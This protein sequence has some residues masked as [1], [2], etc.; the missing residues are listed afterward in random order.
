MNRLTKFVASLLPRAR[1]TKRSPEKNKSDRRASLGLECLD[2]RCLPSG[3]PLSFSSNHTLYYGSGVVLSNVEQFLWSSQANTG[4]ALQQGGTVDSFISSSPSHVHATLGTNVES[5]ALAAD[6]TLYELL[7]GG[8]LQVSTNAGKSWGVIDTATEQ[9][10]VASNGGL[11]DLDD[12]GGLNFS[13]NRGT[14]WNSLDGN[15]QSIAVTPDDTLF[16]LVSGGVLERSIDSGQSWTTIDS[17]V[18]SFAAT[19]SDTLYGLD[20]GG[21]LWVLP[22]GG[23]RKVL[24]TNTEAFSSTAGGTLYNLTI[25]GN[26]KFSTNSGGSFT[27]IDG[28]AQSF[29]LATNGA[30][31]TLDTG[32]ELRLLSTQG[33]SWQ[34][35]DAAT[36]SF[37]LAANGT[38]YDLDAGGLLRELSM[39]GAAWQTLDTAAQSLAITPNGTI[40]VLDP[41]GVLWDL[42]SNG[43]WQWQGNN[44]QSFD[45][46][47]DGMFYELIEGGLLQDAVGP[48]GSWNTLDNVTLSFAVSPNGTLY[49][50]DPGNQLWELQPGGDW[51]LWDSATQAFTM[52]ANGTIFDLDTSNALWALPYD[53]SWQWFD[54]NTQ[55][56]AVNGNGTLFNLL[57]NGVLKS[58]TNTGNS[59]KTL[60]STS[61]AFDVTPNGTIE[62]LLAG[63]TPEASL[64]SGHSWYDLFAIVVPD[65]GVATLARSD[66]ARD[67]QLTRADMIGLFAEVEADG[68][69]SSAEY[70]SLQALT[71][72]AAVA[73]PEDV[74]NLAGKIVNGNEANNTFEGQSLG[75]IGPG[76][77][78][79][80]LSDLVAKW[81]YGADHPVT[82]IDP[83]TGNP[84]AYAQAGGTLF[85]ASGVPSYN[86]VAQGNAADCY[87]MSSLGQIALQSPQTIENM[88]TNNGDSTYTVRFYN[89]G[90]ADYV[91][92]DS[93]LPVDSSG[94]FVYANYDQYGQPTFAS[95]GTNILWVALA[96]KAYAQLAEEGWSRGSSPNSYDSINYGMMANG[97]AQIT[98]ST[99]HSDIILAGPQATPGAE[100][101]I[102]NDIAQNHLIGIQTLSTL[103]D[104]Q[105]AFIGNHV[106]V[107]ESYDPNTGLFTFINPYDDGGSARV[108][109]V[110]W[111]QLAPYVWVFEDVTAPDGMS[112]SS[113]IGNPSP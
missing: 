9:Y 32:G 66:Y 71:D 69:L 73:M 34:T 15:T 100:S 2:D 31:Y 74:R 68:V 102:L 108:V 11:Y 40:Y 72:S 45:V 88:F 84:Y 41:G 33:G 46:T 55:S 80:Q 67:G 17:Q 64:D 83:T 96:E 61:H 53:G 103:P 82:D 99:V 78:A 51:N 105:T 36:Q 29:S 89:N 60:D 21:S 6:G 25:G 63:T 54:G 3:S 106:Y 79:D 58:S 18:V 39:P 87:F 10:G 50:L 107:L 77:S 14:T 42:A 62:N 70:T 104:D 24:D 30:L 90:V 85:G 4:F 16:N 94:Q 59:W 1:S 13:A 92:V 20:G 65:S 57:S 75:D 27:T 47:S 76:S 7:Y 37:S 28:N 43:Y 101:L 97:M 52:T 56:Y 109:Q 22:L 81:F 26:L 23:S 113:V 35:L 19:T 44:V 98:G 86:D 91:T 38:V 95:S 111:D 112:A 93:N 5:I 8:Q 49:D 110:T 12:G 48:N